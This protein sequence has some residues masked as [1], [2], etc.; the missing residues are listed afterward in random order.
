MKNLIGWVK[1]NESVDANEEKKCDCGDEE[2]GIC[3][4][5]DKV[6][7]KKNPFAKMNAKK[8]EE[9]GEK[10]TAAKKGEKKEGGEKKLSKAQMNLPW[11]KNKKK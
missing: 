7:E 11:N 8:K 1:F 2:C 9:K 3:N 6:E 10:K 4:P 5:Q